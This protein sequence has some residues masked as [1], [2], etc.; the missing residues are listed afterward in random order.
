MNP[1]YFGV[2][3]IRQG[4][5]NPSPPHECENFG[6]GKMFRERS[7]LTHFLPRKPSRVSKIRDFENPV[8]G[9]G[10]FENRNTPT[11]QKVGQPHLGDGREKCSDSPIRSAIAS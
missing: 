10:E 9:R 2:S 3:F 6:V 1:H 11:P 8:L 4:Y 5:Q 7:E